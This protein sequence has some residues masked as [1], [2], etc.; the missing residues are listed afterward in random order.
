MGG[1]VFNQKS[2]DKFVSGYEREENEKIAEAFESKNIIPSLPKDIYELSNQGTKQIDSKIRS[3]INGE[4]KKIK[5]KRGKRLIHDRDIRSRYGTSRYI[6]ADEFSGGRD[7]DK[8]R[9]RKTDVGQYHGGDRYYLG[10]G[11]HAMYAYKTQ[12]VLRRYRQ[13]NYWFGDPPGW[14]G[15][16]NGNSSAGIPLYANEQ[17]AMYHPSKY[18]EGYPA[19]VYM[20]YIINN[21]PPAKDYVYWTDYSN[22]IGRYERDAYN[23][24]GV[25]VHHKGDPRYARFRSSG[26]RV[27]E[28][29]EWAWYKRGDKDFISRIADKIN[30]MPVEKKKAKIP[31]VKVNWNSSMRDLR[32][33][34]VAYE[35]ARM[36]VEVEYTVSVSAK[37]GKQFK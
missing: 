3:M 30:R 19:F 13:I 23:R 22:P 32:T 24:K 27:G 34:E 29:I 35:A 5:T 2:I 7:W 33:G 9:G 28:R 31:A 1:I 14:K 12:N 6:N 26:E 18:P 20:P 4:L 10:Y 16:G 37:V 21:Q 36:K 17:S 25:L 8:V 15:G 11:N